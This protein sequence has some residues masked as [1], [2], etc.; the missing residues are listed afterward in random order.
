MSVQDLSCWHDRRTVDNAHGRS[1]YLSFQQFDR[2]T[3]RAEAPASV[4]DGAAIPSARQLGSSTDSR[5]EPNIET[6]RSQNRVRT[7]RRRASHTGLQI[8][9]SK[10]EWR[11][12]R[13]NAGV[14][15][16]GERM[17]PLHLSL[18]DDGE[19]KVRDLKLN[20]TREASR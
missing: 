2:A 11:R 5:S 13:R 14:P 16:F 12:W 20:F 8:L 17:G 4:T 19:R 7:F 18:R 3:D 6:E 15:Q 1:G 10:H 9:L